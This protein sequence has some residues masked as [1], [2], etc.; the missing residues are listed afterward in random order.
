MDI[1]KGLSGKLKFKLFTKDG[2]T[3]TLNGASRVT[4]NDT[5]SLKDNS[6]INAIGAKGQLITYELNSKGKILRG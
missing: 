1:E 4:V 3:L 2:E 5:G 6:V